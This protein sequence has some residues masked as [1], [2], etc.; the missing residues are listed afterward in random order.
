MLAANKN[1]PF[2]H[3]YLYA[4]TQDLISGIKLKQTLSLCTQVNH[5]TSVSLINH[6]QRVV[7]FF[8]LKKHHVVLINHNH[9]VLFQSISISLPPPVS[10]QHQL[11][12]LAPASHTLKP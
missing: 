10:L 3:E 1:I 12:K 7:L 5:H 2:T 4:S 8:G 6:N 9:V 11:H